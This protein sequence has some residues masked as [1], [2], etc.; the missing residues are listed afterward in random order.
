MSSGESGDEGFLYGSVRKDT[1]CE[2]CGSTAFTRNDD[3]NLVCD[4][5]GVILSGNLEIKEDI[6]L[7]RTSG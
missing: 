6:D 2:E 4:D 7:F 3:G 5:C 1:E